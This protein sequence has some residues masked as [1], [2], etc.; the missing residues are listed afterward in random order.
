MHGTM[1]VYEDM[2]RPPK[3][4]VR[5][6]AYRL[7]EEANRP[8]GKSDFFWYRAELSLRIK[9]NIKPEKQILGEGFYFCPNNTGEQ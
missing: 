2:Y 6:E 3:E 7:W 5:V 9:T 4:Q 1:K 8:E